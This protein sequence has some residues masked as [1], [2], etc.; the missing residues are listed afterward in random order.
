[1]ADIL[2]VYGTLTLGAD[3]GLQADFLGKGNLWI[4]NTY[5]EAPLRLARHII[6]EALLHTAPGQLSILGYDSDLSGVF[7]PFAALSAG[8]TKQFEFIADERALE[9]NLSYL[10]QQVRDV[11]NVIQGRCP[12]LSA[13]RRRTGRPV[14]GYRLVVL[15][16]DMGLIGA[17]LRTKLSQLMRSAPACGISFLI[18]STTYLSIQTGSGRDIELTV[19]SLAPNIT[20]LEAGGDR[21]SC[22][23]DGKSVSYRSV[24]AEEIIEHCARFLEAAGS[25]KMPA[26]RFD[27]LHDMKAVWQEN[28]TDGLT[29]S[30][31]KYGVNDMRITIGD[32]VNQRHNAVITGAVGQ[33]KSNLIAVIVHSLCQQYSPKELRLYMLDFKEG[34]SLKPYSNLGQEEY[35]PHAVALGLESDVSFGAAV[36]EELFGEYRRRMQI[37]KELSLKSVRELRRRFP[38]REM[39][40]IVVIIDEF[41]MMFGDDSPASLQAAALLEKSIRLFR[42]AGIHFILASQTLGGSTALARYHESIFSQIPIRIALKNTVEESYQT[43]ELNNAAAAFLRPREA[44]V[45]LDYGRA[46]QNQKTVV[47]FADEKLLLPQRRLWWE[48]ARAYCPPPYVFENG[49][50]VTVS[51]CLRSIGALRGGGRPCAVIGER[52][53]VNGEPVRLPMTREPGRNIAIIGT[54]DRD[55]DQAAGMVQSAAVSLALQHPRGDARFLFCDFTGEEEACERRYPQF[56]RL[57][58]NS[59]Y[60]V[61]SIPR[62]DFAATLSQLQEEGGGGDAVYVLGFGMDRWEYEKDPYGAGSPLQSFAET[63]PGRNMHFIGWWTKAA[64]FTKQAAGFGDTEAFNS[65]I[66]LR[67]DER[68][69]QSLTSPFVRWSSQS[70]RALL[71]DP[72]E[73]SDEVRFIPFAP[74]TAGDAAAFKALIL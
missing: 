44:I 5:D 29:F 39:P 55:C 16:M 1:M 18:V 3:G 11:Q 21:V 34:V 53:S 74:V 15:S 35:L 45:N 54:P 4:N 46:T 71:W 50:R 52:I 38:D 36:L 22:G 23:R 49:K 10:W 7:A 31:G 24:T 30:I 2:D 9:K 62:A 57:M 51:D 12:T 65:R 28:S 72:V 33:G 66:F 20:V 73:L 32:E 43:L 48:R 40:R 67:V 56:A 68:S 41:Q 27:E 69:V 25:A 17:E 8:E 63:A 26:I 19:G 64:S 47:A 13:F 60:C 70:N 42:A 59:G 58:E 61:E 37:L 6:H 14:E